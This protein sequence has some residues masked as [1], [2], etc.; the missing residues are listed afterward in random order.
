M[1]W[2]REKYFILFGLSQKEKSWRAIYYLLILFLGSILF[3]AIVS[4][5]VYWGF[6]K[7]NQFYPNLAIQYIL[8]KGLDKTFDRLRWLPVLLFLPILLW[9]VHL[10]TA[11]KLGLVFQSKH[12]LITLKWFFIGMGM[13]GVTAI[14]QYNLVVF[15]FRIGFDDFKEML[16]VASGIVI[17][18][19]FAALIIGMIEEIVFRGMVFRFFYTAMRPELAVTLSAL[20]FAW[21]HFK[22]IP[23]EIMEESI[24]TTWASGF[25]VAFWTLLSFTQTLE[26]IPFLNLFLS[27]LILNLVF[28]KNYS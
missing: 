1:N 20:F 19:F 22:D 18:A 26:W 6:E 11:K 8:D 10:F 9:H 24:T 21:T 4:P 2:P 14:I 23:K 28:L 25:V 5:W 7:W 15:D 16:F 3:A 17:K 27:G 13:F 12:L